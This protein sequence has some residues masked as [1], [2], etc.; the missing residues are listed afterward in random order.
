[1]KGDAMSAWIIFGLIGLMMAGSLCYDMSVLFR[2][3]WRRKYACPHCHGGIMRRVKDV[4]DL[5]KCDH[6]GGWTWPKDERRLK[7]EMKRNRKKEHRITRLRKR[8]RRRAAKGDKVSGLIT[9]LFAQQDAIFEVGKDL[10]GTIAEV[11]VDGRVTPPVEVASLEFETELGVPIDI[12]EGQLLGMEISPLD[13]KFT[14]LDEG[15]K[16][17]CGPLCPKCGRELTFTTDPWQQ[18]PRDPL[19]ERVYLSVA[20]QRCECGF[21]EIQHEVAK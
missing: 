13:V 20:L 14:F 17:F 7:R 5:L 11:N 8:M 18:M 4:P 15:G 9:G 3:Y 21:P 16:P 1:M 19:P 6:C 2:Q 10:L 12:F